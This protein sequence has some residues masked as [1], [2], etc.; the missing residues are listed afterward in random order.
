MTLRRSRPRARRTRRPP[1]VWS[2]SRRA[3]KTKPKACNVGLFLARG[4]LLVIYDAEDR[5]S[6]SNYVRRSRP[7]SR[8]AHDDL[9]A[10]AT[11]LLELPTNLLTRMF[12]LE[13]GYWFGTM[14][15]GLDRWVCRYRSGALPTTFRVSALRALIGWDPH[16][17]TEDADLGVRAASTATGWGDRFR[18]G[19]GGLRGAA[20][21]DPAAHPVDQG[22]YADG[23]R[24]LALAA[25]P[26]TPGRDRGC[27][28]FLLLIAGTPLTFLL[29]PVMWVGTAAVVRLRRAASAARELGGVLAIAMINLLIGNGMMVALNLMAAV[30]DTVGARRRTPS[31][32]PLLGAPF[33]RC[34]ARA[35]AVDPQPVLLGED[36]PRPRA[37]RATERTPRNSP[38]TSVQPRS[39]GANVPPGPRTA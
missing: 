1:S 12:S 23:A 4:D 35:G 27:V 17:V 38:P 5:R 7:S 36:A 6:P 34:V 32:P 10:G 9:P 29:A 22:L 3:P 20:P 16:N 11:A 30:A 8:R 33:D 24:A 25:A 39:V 31:Q 14:L 15:P 2:S 37:R 13:Y 18:H 28:W 19:R 21:L 26:G